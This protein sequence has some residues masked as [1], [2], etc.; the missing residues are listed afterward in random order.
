MCSC[1]IVAGWNIIYIQ[2]DDRWW[3][4]LMVDSAT[5]S[6]SHGS[7]ADHSTLIKAQVLRPRYGCRKGTWDE[8]EATHQRVHD[9]RRLEAAY[10]DGMRWWE[11]T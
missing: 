3:L 4:E 2:Q 10:C 6:Q 1:T 11:E 7:R 8:T 9:Q 5:M